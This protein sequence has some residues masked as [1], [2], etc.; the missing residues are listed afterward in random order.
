MI[1]VLTQSLKIGAIVLVGLILVAGS[2]AFFNYWTDRTRSAEIGRPVTIQ[3]TED[4]DTSSVADKLTHAKLVKY[5]FYF[6]ARMRLDGGELRPGTYTILKGDSVSDI[7]KR[8]T[9]PDDASG[10]GASGDKAATAPKAINVTFVEGWRLEQFGDALEEAGFPNGRE[11]FMKAA[12]NPANRKGF[13]FLEGL[14]ADASLEGFLFPDT[15]RFGSDATAD[16]IVVQMLTNFDNKFTPEMRAQQKASGLSMLQVMTVASI[17][18][19]EAVVPEERPVIA[20]VY[21]NRIDQGMQLNAD[22]TLQYIIG[23]KDDWWPKVTDAALASDSPYNTYKVVG[24]PPGPISNPG[25]ASI[26]AVLQPAD[27]TYLYF[28]AKDD[29]SNTHVFANTNDEQ[30]QNRCTYL[31]DC[32]DVT[33]GGSGGGTNEAATEQPTDDTQEIV[34]A[35]Q[36]DNGGG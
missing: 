8:I 33:G 15:Y 16:Q 29:G 4:D 28:V 25:L 13:D 10:S 23:N 32:G 36:G 1:R 14:P 2:A 3:I 5:G 7:I 6:Q 22:P 20:K 24:L 9:V 31:G 35:D 34:P 12:A 17:V 26:Q 21:L 19:R 11:A 18:E 27:V 30:N